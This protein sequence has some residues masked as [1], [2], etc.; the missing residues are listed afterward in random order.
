MKQFKQR[1][2]AYLETINLALS[3]ALPLAGD[4]YDSVIEAMRYSVMDAGK[5]IRPVLTLEFCRVFG[6][7]ELQTAQLKMEELKA[8]KKDETV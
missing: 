5:R 8:G 7:E 4:S 2:D 6:G 1:M 3:E